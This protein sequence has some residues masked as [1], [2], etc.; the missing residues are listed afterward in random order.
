MSTKND[1]SD[2]LKLGAQYEIILAGLF[3]E[4]TTQRKVTTELE[5]IVNLS[6]NKIDSSLRSIQELESS[7]KD[8]LRRVENGLSAIREIEASFVA[9]TQSI[10]NGNSVLSNL[11]EM[12]SK[13]VSRQQLINKFMLSYAAVSAILFIVVWLTKF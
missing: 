12:I 11:Q 3:D 13:N 9:I 6:L 2:F 1:V 8:A 10:D 5:N 7:S 4:L